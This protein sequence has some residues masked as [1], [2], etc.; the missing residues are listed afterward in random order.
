MKGTEILARKCFFK[1]FLKLAKNASPFQAIGVTTEF[2]EALKYQ[3]TVVWITES[4]VRTIP[5][6]DVKALDK[7]SANKVATLYLSRGQYLLEMQRHLVTVYSTLEFWFVF[8]NH[9]SA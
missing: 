1:I 4:K 6:Y 8:E 2:F 5:C 9:P 7:K 3:F